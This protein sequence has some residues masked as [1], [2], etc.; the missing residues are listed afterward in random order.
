MTILLSFTVLSVCSMTFLGVTLYRQFV[1]RSEDSAKESTAQLLSQTAINLEDYLRSMRRI[2]DAMYYSVI[3]NK[4]LSTETMDD[5]MNLLYQANQD[6]LISIACYTND[7]TLIT[8]AP[9]A[10]Q[11]S[12]TDVTGQEWF[13]N[14]IDQMEN[15]HFSTPHVQNLF[16]ETTYRY[17]WVV[18]LSRA[19]ELTRGGNSSLGVLLVD[20]NYSSIEQILS[21]A[22]ANSL[23]EY[24]YLMDGEG[25]IIYHPKQ[26][27]IYSGIF[28]ENNIGATSYEDGSIEEIF[29]GEKRLVTVK[30]ISYTGWKIVSVVP[31]SSFEMGLSTTKYFVIL[32]VGLSLLVVVLINRLVSARIAKPLQKLNTSVQ[33]WEAGNLNPSIYVGG[34]AEVE[35]LGRTLRSTVEQNQQLMHDI[36]IEQEEKRKSELDALQSQINP[37]FLYNT[38]DSV[39]WMIE[40]ERYDDAV[41]MITELASLFRISLS[42]GK[43]I[44]SIEDEVK[45]AENYMNIQKVRFRNK[46]KVEFDVEEEIKHC[47]T[48]KLVLQPLLENAIYYGV[49][50]MDGDGI[51]AVRGYRS[52]EFVIL[53]VE[54]NGLGMTWDMVS[55]IMEGKPHVRSHGSGVGLK[56]VHNRIALRFGPEYGLSIDSTPDEGTR[57]SIKLPYIVYSEETAEAL[58]RGKTYDKM[59]SKEERR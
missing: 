41:F 14:A 47:C 5:E 3:K 49:E 33:E 26:K 37:H 7:G 29:G 27:Q 35:H 59:A 53:K 28:E 56:N 54:D 10:N 58:E 25:E 34:S 16:D 22:N 13:Q 42:R 40:G 4:D 48:V 23:D 30:T 38:L 24:V 20:M 43:T 44:I 46:F 12:R 2:S 50:Y 21:K 32:L 51:I 52:G 6:S 18:S 1:Q 55:G 19:V 31:L 8:A 17:Y 36:V 11:K 9:I 39:V 15:L 57:V 45:H